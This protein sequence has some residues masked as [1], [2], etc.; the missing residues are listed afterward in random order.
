MFPEE[1]CIC[2]KFMLK[3]ENNFSNRFNSHKFVFS[4][5]IVIGSSVSMDKTVL[6]G[7]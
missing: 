1:H 6:S 3:F 5:D 7:V 4:M 2:P